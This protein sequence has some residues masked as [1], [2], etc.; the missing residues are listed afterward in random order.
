MIPPTRAAFAVPSTGNYSSN[1]TPKV[2]SSF[3]VVAGDLIVVKSSIANRESGTASTVTPSLSGGSVT[4]TPQLSTTT[5]VAQSGAW[6]WTG[7]VGAS[8]TGVTLT[9][10]R[11]W[12]FAYEW[13][14]SATLYRDHGGVGNLVSGNN[15]TGAGLPNVSQTFSENSAVDFTIND[16]NAIDGS[17][18]DYI[19]INGEEPVGA[20][21]YFNSALHTVYGAYRLD[22]G[23]AGSKSIGMVAP[24]GQRWVMAGVE[25][26]GTAGVPPE[27]LGS[28]TNEDG[29][30]LLTEDGLSIS[31]EG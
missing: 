1:A 11:P 3:D 12:S 8:A 22:V 24:G 5:V 31:Y 23:V 28:L 4:W 29:T 26:L 9:L 27:S 13:G 6:L 30:L 15:G 16:W 19:D 10:A 14:F 7:I 2:S 17:A 20:T 18:R 25:I 21:Y